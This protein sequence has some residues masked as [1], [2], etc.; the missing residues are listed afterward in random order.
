MLLTQKTFCE[1]VLENKAD[2]ALP[3]KENQKK[4]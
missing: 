4:K 2:Y 1:E 3:V